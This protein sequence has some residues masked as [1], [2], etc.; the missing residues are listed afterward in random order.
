VQPGHDGHVGV[1]GTPAAAF[2]EQNHRQLLIQR[3]A[4][5]AVGLGMVAHALRAGQHG[6]VVGHDHR[7]TGFGA[8]DQA[9]DAADAGHHAVSRRVAHQVVL[10][11][12]AALGGDGQRAV[13]Q[14]AALVAQVGDVLPRGALALRVAARHGLGTGGVLREG[15]ALLQALQVDPDGGGGAGQPAWKEIFGVFWRY[16]A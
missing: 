10:A 6:R 5:Q 12:P 15:E 2:G 14:K 1:T 4:Q 16:P 9:I 11:A 3:D 7:A 13:F 8:M